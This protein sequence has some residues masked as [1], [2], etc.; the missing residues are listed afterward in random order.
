M[1]ELRCDAETRHS[2]ADTSRLNGLLRS[3]F[4]RDDAAWQEEITAMQSSRVK[5]ELEALNALG[6]EYLS[7]NFIIEAILSRDV[8]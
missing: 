5:C 8:A 4:I 6:I 1:D 3:P 2:R 7:H